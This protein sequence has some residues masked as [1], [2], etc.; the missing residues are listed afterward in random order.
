MEITYTCNVSNYSPDNQE[1]DTSKI[2][3]VN[4]TQSKLQPSKMV[5]NS[6]VEE[7]LECDVS[8][9][10]PGCQ[11]CDGSKFDLVDPAQSDMQPENRFQ[12]TKK[13]TSSS[14][15]IKSCKDYCDIKKRG[16]LNPVKENVQ[17]ILTCEKICC[18]S[19]IIEYD[20]VAFPVSADGLFHESDDVPYLSYGKAI[21]QELPDQPEY[22]QYDTLPDK[23]RGVCM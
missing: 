15:F 12:S 8:N 10:S 16:V 9:Y 14:N 17:P 4:H 23:K 1:C 7:T 5:Q 11:Q 22:M 6:K 3:M 13:F 20:N 18:I 21:I 19:V 2:E